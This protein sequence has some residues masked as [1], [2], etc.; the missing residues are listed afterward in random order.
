MSSLEQKKYITISLNDKA[1]KFEFQTD[2]NY[3]IEYKRC[4]LTR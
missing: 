1:H 2:P 4:F 3:F